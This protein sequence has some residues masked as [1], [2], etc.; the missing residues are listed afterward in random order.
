[1]IRHWSAV[2]GDLARDHGIT[3]GE[4]A[5]MSTRR[6]LTLVTSLSGD[7]RFARAWQHTPR[8]ADSPEDIARITG[9]PAQ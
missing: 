5:R 4:L 2:E 1:M 9:I 3:S 6:F 7:S 8:R